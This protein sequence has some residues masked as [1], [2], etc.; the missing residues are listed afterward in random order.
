MLLFQ[1]MLP[2]ICDGRGRNIFPVY[3]R[4]AS[5]FWMIVVTESPL[6]MAHIVKS[7]A[8]VFILT[9]LPSRSI[10]AKGTSMLP[11]RLVSLGSGVATSVVLAATSVPVTASVEAR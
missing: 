4:L 6:V 7:T 10:E 5:T 1:H 3:L 9:S 11:L 2:V 8:I